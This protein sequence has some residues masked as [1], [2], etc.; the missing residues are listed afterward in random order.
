[1][2]KISKD[3]KIIVTSVVLAV[4]IAL[5]G[6]G[7]HTWTEHLKM[8]QAQQRLQDAARMV[9]LEKG[10]KGLL[11]IAGVSEEEDEGPLK[12][13]SD[14][15]SVFTSKG[16]TQYSED[17]QE[18]IDIYEDYNQAVV[19]INTE[20]YQYTPFQ[21]AIPES[22][23]GSGS[24]ID[25][26]GHIVTNYHVIQNS[27]E[28]YVS[29]HDGTSFEGEVI[30]TD[31]ENDLAVIKIDPRGKKLTTVDF[32]SSS[33]LSI[34]QKVLAIG[35]PFGYDRTLTTGIISGLNRPIKTDENLVMP[36]MIQTDASIN[37]GNSGGPLLDSR[38]RLIGISSSIYTTTGGSMG[39][40]FAVPV[41]TAARVIPELIEHGR[42][43]RGWLDITPVQLDSRIAEY[44]NLPVDTGI[45]VS[46][47]ESDGKAEQAGIRGG[48]ERVKYGQK[49]FNLDGDVIIEIEGVEIDDFADYFSALE[50][51]KPGDTVNIVL[52]RGEKRIT[53]DVEL[54]ERPEQVELE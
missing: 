42:V 28:V 3:T 10:E 9:M 33:N 4:V 34:G 1:M 27:D 47:V 41:D 53:L 39:I 49:I 45:L 7:I 37:P 8:Q 29:L 54:I 18:N 21:E 25:Q 14:A 26:E 35:N 32:G 36:N 12:I 38:G 11:E 15:L 13:I 44:A 16:Q 23:T 17:E 43:V 5:A 50:A 24:I 31:K 46:S 51:T 48:T 6:Y 40:G 52:L 19:N 30:G 22:G 2:G 20:V